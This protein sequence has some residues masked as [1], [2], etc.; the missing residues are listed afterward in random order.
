MRKVVRWLCGGML[1][2]FRPDVIVDTAADIDWDELYRLGIRYCI[3]DVDNT[4]AGGGS[5]Y[6]CSNIVERIKSAT[7]SKKLLGV[8]VLSNVIVRTKKRQKRLM[9]IALTIGTSCVVS[10]GFCRQK[11][12]PWGFREAMRKMDAMGLETA[13]VGDLL[14]TDIFG[15]K[16]SGVGVTIW[17]RKPIGKQKP[18]IRVRHFF[19]RF[20]V[21]IL[22][23]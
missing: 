15:G 23:L 7:Q 10:L 21:W 11:P 13:A 17:T 4:L 5:D 1:E 19:E 20:I 12:N 3:W 2:W 22:E 8:C 9:R 6:V 14:G 18:H 16:R